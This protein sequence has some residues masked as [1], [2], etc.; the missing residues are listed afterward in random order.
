M[1]STGKLPI[2]VVI[3]GV[4][5]SGSALV[6]GDA[7]ALPG[8]SLGVIDSTSEEVQKVFTYSESEKADLKKQ[9]AVERLAEAKN[10]GGETSEQLYSEYRSLMEDSENFKAAGSDASAEMKNK[11]RSELDT[12]NAVKQSSGKPFIGTGSVVSE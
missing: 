6:V 9:L 11:L 7:G 2:A 1:E 8:T 12:L 3:V 5:A 4:L 10:T